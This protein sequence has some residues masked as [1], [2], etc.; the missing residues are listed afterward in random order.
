MNRNSVSKNLIEVDLP[1]KKRP[2]K[3]RAN[4]KY[5]I[6]NLAKTNI[7]LLCV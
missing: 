2:S 5:V 7:K 6:T 4:L 1:L 3:T